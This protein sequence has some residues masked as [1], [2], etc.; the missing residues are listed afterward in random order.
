[1][2]LSGRIT[3]VTEL[4]ADERTQMFRLMCRHY[5]NVSQAGF[6]ADLME[7]RWIIQLYSP[8]GQ[9]CG[10]S[11][12]TLLD[13]VL[14]DRRI[15]ALFSGDTVVDRKH[16]GDPALAC[17]GGR[18]AMSLIDDFPSQELYWF[19][20]SAGYKTYRFLPVFFHEFYPRCD[21]T[22]PDKIQSVIAA[23]ARVKYPTLYDDANGVIRADARQYRLREGVADVSAG[24]QRDPHV[25]FFISRN[26]GH[27]R[28]DELC[29]IAPL[30]REN[31]TPAAYRVL[32]ATQPHK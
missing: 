7:K 28:G 32:G 5:E 25:E 18:L 12:Q 10:F 30:R 21:A 11:T 1:M 17:I 15:I 26:P 22:T 29:C 9:L 20:I 27:V 23:L 14:E 4:S 16:W 6:D 3:T 2:A 24:R 31:F 13:I 19:L 8:G